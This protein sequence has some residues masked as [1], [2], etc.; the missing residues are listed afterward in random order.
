MVETRNIEV[1]EPKGIQSESGTAVTTQC[2]HTN[3]TED[4]GDTESLAN[5]NDPGAGDGVWNV[6]SRSER[7]RSGPLSV[8]NHVARHC[9]VLR[10]TSTSKIVLVAVLLLSMMTV[11]SV[12]LTEVYLDY[13]TVRFVLPE[14]C[15]GVGVMNATSHGIFYNQNVTGTYEC[16]IIVP[17]DNRNL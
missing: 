6:S 4:H 5:R 2:M 15:E 10:S 12:I 7:T 3:V 13:S 11:L 8:V 1:S 14:D 9:P 17:D 16:G